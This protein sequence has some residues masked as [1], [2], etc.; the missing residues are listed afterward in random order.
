MDLLE[1]WDTMTAR[2]F[3]ALISGLPPE[4]QWSHALRDRK[5]RNFLDPTLEGWV[6]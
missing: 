3:Y 5:N 1:Q 6:S 2:R 4:S